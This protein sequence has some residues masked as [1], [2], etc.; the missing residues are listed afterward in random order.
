LL[1][2]GFDPLVMSMT[3]TDA[4]IVGGGP[5]GLAA[6]IAL[7]QK[8]L[9]AVVADCAIPPIDKACGE[10]L[11]PDSL[12]ALSHLGV[13]LDHYEVGEFRGI[14]FIEA[15]SSVSADFPNGMGLGIRRTLLHRAL[16]RRASELGVKFL[17]GTR[18]SGLRHGA[19]LVNGEPVTCQWI[20]GADGHNSQVQKWAGLSQSHDRDRRIAIRQHFSV[21]RWSDYVEVYWG[22][23]GQAYVTPIAPNEVCVALISTR[24]WESF[25][26]GLLSFPELRARLATGAANTKAK[27]A[28]TICRRLRSVF[29]NNVALIGEASGSVD[30]ITG[31]GMALAFRQAAALAEAIRLG[32]LSTYKA[33]H[34]AIGS[35]PAFM[36]R[37]MLLMDKSGWLR[38]RALRSFQKEPELFRRL[39]SFHVGETGVGA[40]LRLGWQ[41][42]TA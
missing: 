16:C 23:R 11:M 33:A 8:G 15:Q 21:A 29:R 36:S 38:G 19:V 7:R 41:L 4:F 28:V 27:G 22:R 24:R 10:G 1:G 13:T 14:S 25:E 37:A 6:A 30:A 35:R 34:D 5:A 26:S 39:L 2:T 18:V 31:D 20:I 17:W 42:V 12:E 32:D 40:F 3:S 9:S